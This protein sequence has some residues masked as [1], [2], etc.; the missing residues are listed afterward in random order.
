MYLAIFHCLGLSHRYA[1]NHNWSFG[2][3]VDYDS[4]KG[5]PLGDRPVGTKDM[6]ED[7]ARSMVALHSCFDPFSHP[8]ATVYFSQHYE[9]TRLEQIVRSSLEC[10]IQQYFAWSHLSRARKLQLNSET[11]L[12]L[13]LTLTP[14]LQIF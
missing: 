6:A 1:T 4:V 14:N 3:L 2:Y 8:Q 12:R 11:L 7:L 9:K 13:P 10:L 5:R